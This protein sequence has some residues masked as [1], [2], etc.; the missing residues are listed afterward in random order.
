[1]EVPR[2]G[3]ELE[4]PMS[5][6]QQH[7]IRASSVTYATAC[8]NA[9]SF[10]PLSEARNWTR[11]LRHCIRFLTH[12]AHNGNS[13]IIFLKAALAASGSSQARDWILA[14]AVTYTATVA[15]PDPLAHCSRP[16]I[17][18]ALCTTAVGFLTH[19]TTARTP[20]VIFS[21]THIR[22]C[23]FSSEN[24]LLF[25]TALGIKSKLLNMELQKSNWTSLAKYS[26]AY[27]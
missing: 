21:K 22:L 4:L 17:Q 6:P 1:M 10:N 11:I 9:R 25:P 13:L 2:Q 7:W 24:H 3:V 5:H 20:R 27:S 23:H 8:S 12:W 19:C 15:M 18:P 26:M 14:V 16:G